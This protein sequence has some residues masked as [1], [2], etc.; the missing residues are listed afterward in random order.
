MPE[1]ETTALSFGTSI[2]SA[3]EDKTDGSTERRSAGP[4]SHPAQPGGGAPRLSASLLKTPHSCGKGLGQKLSQEQGKSLA[5]ATKGQAVSRITDAASQHCATTVKPTS[6]PITRTKQVAKP[7]SKAK[8]KAPP[9]SR[10]TA[11]KKNSP[12]SKVTRSARQVKHLPSKKPA[13]NSKLGGKP[14]KD[15]QHH[16]S[17]QEHVHPQA[18]TKRKTNSTKSTVLPQNIEQPKKRTKEIKTKKKTQKNISPS[19]NQGTP[20][21]SDEL[22]KEGVGRPKPEVNAVTEDSRIMEVVRGLMDMVA[23]EIGYCVPM[24]APRPTTAPIGSGVNLPCSKTTSTT[25]F[26]VRGA[27]IA[28]ERFV[29]EIYYPFLL[30]AKQDTRKESPSA[31]RIRISTLLAIREVL[32]MNAAKLFTFAYLKQSPSDSVEED[33][34]QLPHVLA[35]AII[36]N[37]AKRLHSNYP[38]SHFFDNFVQATQNYDAKSEDFQLALAPADARAVYTTYDGRKLGEQESLLAKAG[39][40][41]ARTKHPL[42]CETKVAKYCDSKEARQVELVSSSPAP[43]ACAAF[44]I[45]LGVADGGTED[46]TKTLESLKQMLR[47]KRTREAS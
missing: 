5:A 9:S 38:E 37:T 21:T 4:P 36:R 33:N 17:K 46:D 32:I 34:T 28:V 35:N 18:K 20:N 2:T 26:D 42:L 45:E 23:D 7:R 29:M 27:V 19:K 43:T 15:E 13:P 12:G 6:A 31:D 1:A 11:T 40:N 44:H 39:F 24:F 22:G 16:T 3:G 47:R 41:R 10:G 14:T 30:S 25:G 8:S